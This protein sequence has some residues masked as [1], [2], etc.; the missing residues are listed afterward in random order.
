MTPDLDI[1]RHFVQ[2]VRPPPG[3]IL[4]V[5]VTGAHLYGFPS[6][7]SDID[8]KGLHLAPTRD[9]LGLKSVPD[10]HDVTAMHESIE[11]DLT[12]H[13]VGWALRA[14]LKG[15]GNLLERIASP[16]QVFETEAVTEL[17]ELLPQLISRRVH[18]HYAGFFR[19]TCRFFD[20][21]PQ[22]KTLLYSIRVALTGLHVLQTGEVQPHL[23]T[24]AEHFGFPE[25][26]AVI[27]AKRTGREKALLSPEAAAPLR[28]RWPELE[29]ALKLAFAKTS[30]PDE[31]PGR[32]AADAWLVKVRR[33]DL[34]AT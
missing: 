15:N 5:G 4:L 12:T 34:E 33:R 22:A 18:A 19:Q 21:E 6:P 7:D 13:E 27:E 2:E 16:L 10:T 3:R 14:L 24:L 9:V 29:E 17:K 11:H 1:A 23:P 20:R 26:D 25:V 8:L 31:A 30:L 28:R 32:E